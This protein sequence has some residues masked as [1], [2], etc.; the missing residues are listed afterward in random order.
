MAHHN[1]VRIHGALR[2]TPAMDAG[3]TDRVWSVED[4][5][6]RALAASAEPVVRPEKRPL[7]LP[8]RPSEA[9]AT[10]ARALPNGGWLR[11]VTPGGAPAPR[12]PEPSPAAPAEPV[13]EVVADPSGQLDLLSWRRLPTRGTQLSLFDEDA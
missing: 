9:P 12:A 3:I 7:R 6:E 4:L 2:V 11:L 13:P 5:V 10:P 8:E 1:F